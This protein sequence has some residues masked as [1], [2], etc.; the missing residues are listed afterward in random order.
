[1]TRKASVREVATEIVARNPS[2][3]ADGLTIERLMRCVE[4]DPEDA[5]HVL[6]GWWSWSRKG[7]VVLPE[8]IGDLTVDGNLNLY[9]NQLESLPAS[10]GR[11]TVG[12]ALNLQCNRLESLPA[13]FGRL[14]VGGDL[15][16]YRNKV[17]SLPASFGG[18]TVG[19]DLRLSNNPVVASLN[20]NSFP[21]LALTLR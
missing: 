16:L 9:N 1:M 14:T 5:S 7:L 8:S 10:F 4:V 6:G 19:G 17:E 20:E 12:G 15:D 18:L 2:A 11:L 13:S 21:G 3:A